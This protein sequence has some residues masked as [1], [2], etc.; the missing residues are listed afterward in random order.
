MSGDGGEEDQVA[1]VEASAPI[2][3]ITTTT[4]TTTVIN[5]TSTTTT[6][7]PTADPVASSS[8]SGSAVNAI[9]TPTTTTASCAATPSATWTS[10]TVATAAE[11]GAEE[12]EGEEEGSTADEPSSS[13]ER[14]LITAE[15]LAVLTREELVEKWVQQEKFIDSIQAKVDVL[16]REGKSD[17]P[18]PCSVQ[19]IVFFFLFLGI[20]SVFS[21]LE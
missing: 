6:I 8:S 2:S 7:Q 17:S 12:E 20:F 10:P 1:K 15:Q 21:F 14:V 4:A 11:D 3:T 9:V 13:P 5:N 19:K 18:T 16:E